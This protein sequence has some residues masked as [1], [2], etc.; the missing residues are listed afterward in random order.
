MNLLILESAEIGRLLPAG[1]RRC[2]HLLRVLKK[3]P[4]ERV[5]AGLRVEEPFAAAPGSLGSAL[6][7]ALDEGG[8]LLSYEPRAEAPPLRPLRLLLGFPRPIQ[9][10]RLLKDLASLGVAEIL[11]CGTEL[12]EKSYLESDLW[13]KGEYRRALLEG[14]EQAANPR[15]P[16]VSR[17]W[18]LRA[19][20]EA[21]G[22]AG[23]AAPGGEPDWAAGRRVCL[24]PSPGALRL[25]SL[26]LEAPLSLAIG[27]ERG[28]TEAELERLRGAGFI[29]AGLSDRILKTETAALAA[30]SL[31][32]AALGY[33]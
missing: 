23:P 5:E 20:L 3:R 18:T 4:G 27:S 19:A 14:A 26:V 1:D 7:E 9:G 8:L 16:R 25:G 33:L 17:H 13:K 28:W 15:I 29:V 31:A 32:L 11:L 12:G 10:G 2:Q 24:H 6:I 30:V 21:M 22:G